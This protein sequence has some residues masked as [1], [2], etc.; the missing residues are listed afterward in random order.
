MENEHAENRDGSESILSRNVVKL[1]SAVYGLAHCGHSSNT[2][3]GGAWRYSR[4]LIFM[5][6]LAMRPCT[7]KVKNADS[8]E[9]S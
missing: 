4:P 7:G 3:C 1:G 8:Q 9:S 6:D 2:H 5:H